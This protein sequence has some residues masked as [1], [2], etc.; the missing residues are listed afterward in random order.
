MAL[1]WP[2]LVC[3]V[4]CREEAKARD[5][6]PDAV[7]LPGGGDPYGDDDSFAAAKAREARAAQQRSHRNLARAEQVSV[8]VAQA[9]QKEDEKMAGFRALLAQG[10]IT[11]QKRA[12]P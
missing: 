12:A 5:A 2:T 3:G 7:R 1:A 10:P 4:A 6:S 11:I 9:Q 8:A